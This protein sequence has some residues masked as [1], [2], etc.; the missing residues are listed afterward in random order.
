MKKKKE[1]RNEFPLFAVHCWRAQNGTGTS[2][3]VLPFVN[4][5]N[6]TGQK[7]SLDL[8]QYV[9]LTQPNAL[10]TGMSWENGAS[11]DLHVQFS[12]A[13]NLN[14][15][16]NNKA[17]KAYNGLSNDVN[18]FSTHINIYTKIRNGYK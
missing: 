17:A 14:R 9:V 11:W 2:F 1:K 15:N 6:G 12:F 7:N 18:K 8:L 10:P 16:E 13:K 4:M 5:E 3:V